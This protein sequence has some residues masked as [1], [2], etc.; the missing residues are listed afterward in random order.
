MQE[1]CASA[2]E[3]AT[4]KLE[5]WALTFAGYS[6]RRGG[7]V[8]TVVE[9]RCASVRGVV[10]SLSS[11]DLNVLD[12]YEGVPTSYRREQSLVTL[13]SGERMP[14]W[15]YRKDVR[16]HAEAAVA[17]DYFR[18][19]TRAYRARGFDEHDLDEALIRSRATTMSEPRIERPYV[20]FV[21]GTLMRGEPNHHYLAHAQ[22]LGMARSE[23]VYALVHL[24]SYPGLLPSG[25]ASVLGELYAINES[26]RDA[27]DVLEGH[28]R[29]YRRMPLELKGATGVEGYLLRQ[30]KYRRFPE[31]AS[32]DWRSLE[33]PRRSSER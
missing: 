11:D 7:A 19:I 31:I 25:T 4:A 18:Q 29:A 20:V 33:R 26:E 15:V 1:R 17:P 23:P 16:V 12:R 6:E 21:Y 30:A 22:Y 32:A 13:A 24:G 27:L 28:P 3:L 2:I 10:Y 8:A 5:G 14:V 9:E